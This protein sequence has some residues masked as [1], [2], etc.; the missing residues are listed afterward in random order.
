MLMLAK[1]HNLCRIL[2]SS[3]ASY[4]THS[5]LTANT[6]YLAI[7]LIKSATLKPTHFS[8]ICASVC[9]QGVSGW[10]SLLAQ[11]K[12][13]AVYLRDRICEV[14]ASNGERVLL[15]RG[16][17]ISFAMTVDNVVAALHSHDDDAPTGAESLSGAAA[18]VA[19]GSSPLCGLAAPMTQLPA[20]LTSE[21]S[22]TP[23]IA[24]GQDGVTFLGSMLFSRGVSGTR[25]V[26]PAEVKTIDGV[27]FHSYGSSKAGYPHAYLT[28]A[29]AIGMTRG[30][31][32]L[33]VSRL[34]KTLKEL[35][36]KRRG[37]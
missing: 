35:V 18:G 27:T 17:P 21:G 4:T 23:Q 20:P 12:D 34:D 13:V 36:R 3:H 15:S 22:A 28:A 19:V 30:D 8:P 6:P 25:V 16:N 31:V 5:T 9:L 7:P 26:N 11:R 14:A 2:L 37:K 24:K 29:A 32:D 1:Q 10:R 33:Y